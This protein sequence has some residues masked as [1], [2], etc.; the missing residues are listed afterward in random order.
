VLYFTVDHKKVRAN[1]LQ[2]ALLVK[3][4]E[5]GVKMDA[6]GVAPKLNL[7]TE[8]GEGIEKEILD[9]SGAKVHQIGE[10]LVIDFENISFFKIGAVDPTADG[11][12][13][14]E[15]FAKIYTPFSGR[16]QLQVK[17]YTDTRKVLGL[18]RAYRD[19]LELSALRSVSAVRVLQNA[20]IPL[21]DMKIAGYGEL[22]E[23][24]ER[25][26]ELA[27][28]SDPLRYTRRVVLSIEP[29]KELN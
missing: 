7:G 22:I 25:L 26:R 8:P 10:R 5:N 11:A 17:A 6:Q 23:T 18:Q 21:K 15:S 27:S 16:Y 9:R 4:T 13:A 29:K 24:P 12:K 14:L 19:N 2:E 28:E 3:L 20:G 1:Q